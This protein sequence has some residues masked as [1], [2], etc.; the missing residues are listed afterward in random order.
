MNNNENNNKNGNG[1]SEQ[2]QK[3]ETIQNDNLNEP[4]VPQNKMTALK[5]VGIVL[6]VFAIPIIIFGVCV[7]IMNFQ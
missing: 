5:I 3:E 1:N 7:L 2:S 4:G 6:L